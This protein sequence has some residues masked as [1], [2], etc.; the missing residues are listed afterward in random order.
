[1]NF[2]QNNARP[3]SGHE[4]LDRDTL[5]VLAG[6]LSAGDTGEHAPGR[7]TG[8]SEAAELIARLIPHLPEKTV[9]DLGRLLQRHTTRSNPGAARYVR[10]GLLMEL[11]ADGNGVLPATRE[12]EA[13]RATRVNG[14]EDQ[15]PAHSTLINAYGTWVRAVRAAMLLVRD[16]TSSK[17]SSA[18]HHSK[19]EPSYSL[20]EVL[21]A[22]IACRDAIGE[23]PTEGEY[24]E[25]RRAARDL[26]RNAGKPAPRYPVRNAW[27]RIFPGWEEFLTAAKRAAEAAA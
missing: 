24:T 26:A 17:V 10:L 20:K 1:M 3:E 15:W 19:F 14:G 11:V 8:V 7:P 21:D 13:Q 27:A 18:N 16:G 12:Y 6:G 22:L 25:W 4:S 9:L 2:D 5:E 23:W